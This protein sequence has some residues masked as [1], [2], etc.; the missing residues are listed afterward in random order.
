MIL[1]RETLQIEMMK[2]FMKTSVPRIIRE[3]AESY[4]KNEE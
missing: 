1:L 3:R 4:L 2:F